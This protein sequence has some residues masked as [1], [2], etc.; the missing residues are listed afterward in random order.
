M[1]SRLSEVEALARRAYGDTARVERRGGT[2]VR[3]LSAGSGYELVV[4]S[5][6][7]DHAVAE[8]HRRLGDWSVFQALGYLVEGMR[9]DRGES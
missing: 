4:W 7:V 5:G 8:L 6:T 2:R 9:R 3:I 1:D